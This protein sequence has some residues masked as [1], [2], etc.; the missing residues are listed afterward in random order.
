[1]EVRTPRAVPSR[2]RFGGIPEGAVVELHAAL[3]M[4][5]SGAARAISIE[6]GDAAIPLIGEFAGLADTFGVRVTSPLS[7]VIR[8]ERAAARE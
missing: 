8:V 2:D 4:I 6:V 1:M 7:G 3:L 5:R